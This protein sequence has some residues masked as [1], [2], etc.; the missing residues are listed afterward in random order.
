MKND[1][2]GSAQEIAWSRGGPGIED[3]FL[4]VEADT[5]TYS[6][7]FAKSR[8]LSRAAVA[9]ALHAKQKETAANHEPLQLSGKPSLVISPRPASGPLRRSHSPAAA[10]CN[11]QRR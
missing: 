7:Q 3:V 6:G 8:D 4:D 9:S 2:A 1:T 10:M 11:T 5:S